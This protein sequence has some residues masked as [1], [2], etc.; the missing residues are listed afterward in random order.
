[1]FGNFT[2]AARKIMVLANK[3]M[4][5]LK[6]PYVGSEHLLLAILKN[7]NE[8]SEK[9]KEYNLTYEYF[10]QEIVDILGIGKEKSEWFLYTPLLKRILEN[11]IVD[12]KENNDS[13][14]TVSHLFS[15]LLEE[16]E[17]VAIRVMLGMG[18]DL[19]ELYHTFSYKLVGKKKGKKGRKLIIDELG[20]DLTKKAYNNELDP[21]IGRDKELSRVLEILSRRTKNNPVL[22]GEA[23]VGKTAL[24]EE[25]ARR[26]ASGD[27]PL[28]LKNKRII[29][30]D[31]GGAVAGTKYR[32]EFEE[33]MRKILKEIEENEDIILFIDEIHTLVGAG[34]AEGAIDASNIFKPALARGKLRCI[35]ATTIQEYKKY[36]EEDSA[37]ERRFQKVIVEVPNHDTVKNI[38]FSLKP[39][40][41][42]Y[43][44][45][46][47]KDEILTQIVSLSEKYIYDRNEPDRSIDILDEVCAKVSLK[48]SKEVRKYKE[49]QKEYKLVLEQK[50]SAI[51]SGNFDD[52]FAYKTKENDL[53]N[54]MNH[55]DLY[56]SKSL[57]QKEVTLK[58]VAEVISSKT[59][60]PIY[61]IEGDTAKSLAQLEKKLH[62]KIIGQDKAIDSLYKVARKI[63]LGF[64]EE[65]ACYCLLFAGPS[66]V[67]KTMLAK[68]FGTNFVGNQS[69][70]KLDMSEY[71]EE[72]AIS[73]ILGAP[74]GYVGYDDHKNIL[75][76]IRNKPYSVLILDEI[77]K[78]H[79][80]IRDLFY[81]ILDEGKIKDARGRTIYFNHVIIIMTSNIGFMEDHIGFT[82]SN[83]QK[84]AEMQDTF[85][86]PFVNRV[87]DVIFF[88]SLKEDHIYQIIQN[89]LDR[90][91]N[92]YKKKKIHIR[93]SH[94][95]IEEIV[96]LSSYPE[97]GARKVEKLIQDKIENFI[98]EEILKEKSNITIKSLKQNQK[99]ICKSR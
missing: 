79:S 12:S 14:V 50:K 58:E 47:L 37:L 7:K 39:I 72:H 41:E 86:L 40:Y 84:M 81:Q 43:H 83:T 35:G 6:H 9:L 63:K 25:L 71:K 78:A 24:V 48:E 59:G 92:K 1:M 80:S 87:D 8:V 94:E 51:I 38:L 91:K 90:L 70:I 73:K 99:N 64:C 26:I 31:M 85:S 23:G 89:Y 62:S 19:D 77:E 16:G 98:I 67:G 44:N 56:H 61:E 29:S 66:G 13:E 55:I 60:I 74:P 15:G 69:V 57:K 45:V 2:E 82:E 18:L 17:G 34:G 4:S 46:L 21:V 27:V 88:E 5:N 97:Y 42:S 65:N 36:I 10:K 52:A 76:E 53:S 49:L 96:N 20:Y 75:E 30:L 68:A 11:A 3:E 33:R 95:A 22:I 54:Q 28:S 32:G 93:I